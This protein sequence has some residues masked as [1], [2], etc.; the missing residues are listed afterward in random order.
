MKKKKIIVIEIIVIVILFIIATLFFIKQYN[1]KLGHN[2]VETPESAN[3]SDDSSESDPTV[4]GSKDKISG[5]KLGNFDLKFLKLENQKEN[6]LYSPLSIKYTL[7]MLSDGAMENSKVQ[8]DNV[9]GDYKARK[10]SNDEHMSFANALFVKNTNTELVKKEYI[11]TLKNKYNADVVFDSFENSNNLNSWVNNKTF[12]LVDD[13]IDDETIARLDYIIVNALAINMD[14][15]QTIQATSNNYEKMYSISYNH[16]KYNYQIPVIMSDEDY[17]SLLFDDRINAKSVELSAAIN[18]YDIV[19]ILGEENIRQTVGKEYDEWKIDGD[20]V[21]TYDTNIFLDKYIKELNE[22]YKKVYSSTDFMMYDDEN[23]K[24]FAKDLKENNGI[25][26]QYVGIMPKNESL[27]NYIEKTN[28]EEINTIISNLKEIKSENFKEGV[29]TEITG[30]I[31]LFNFEYTLELEDD[32]KRIGIED[33]FTDKANL[34]GIIDGPSKIVYASHK[35]NIEFSNDGIRAAA[36]TVMGGAGNA[37][38]GFEYLYDV[39]IERIDITF[40]KPYM[41]LIRDKE[42][43]EVW[44]IGTV[45]NPIEK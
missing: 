26:L 9:L 7:S 38:C 23:I 12:N 43:G 39:P 27:D 37:S 10:Y 17:S 21:F 44:F 41:F 3:P 6:K 35:A 18:N 11:E 45:Y 33:I 22:N 29:I 2:K 16:E 36:A 32:L 31:P 4:D 40:D 28:A 24:V 30:L 13:I 34:S 14:W 19:N 1:E 20:C 5:N 42:S 8:I 25:T 15:K